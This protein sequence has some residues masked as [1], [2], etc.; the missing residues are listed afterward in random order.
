MQNE[1]NPQGKNNLERFLGIGIAAI[2]IGNRFLSSAGKSCV[3]PIR[4]PNPG[5]H[6]IIILHPWVAEVYPVL[7]LGSGGRLLRT[8][9]LRSRLPCTDPTS[10]LRPEMGKKMAEKWSLARQ[11]K[12][13]KNGR[14]LGK[15]AHKWVKNGQFFHFSAIFPPF[16]VQDNRD[17]KTGLSLQSAIRSQPNRL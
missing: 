17:R 7:G 9:D 13:G 8:L 6:W 12:R 11:D 4:V 16:C 15:L 14:K 5:Q 1:I 2:S 10:G 3:L